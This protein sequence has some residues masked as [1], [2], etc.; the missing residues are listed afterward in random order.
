MKKWQLQQRFLNT[1]SHL[2]RRKRKMWE[3]W[4]APVQSWVH[5]HDHT[6]YHEPNVSTFYT[7]VHSAHIDYPFG[8]WHGR[9]GASSDLVGNLSGEE[10][11]WYI[12]HT[13]FTSNFAQCRVCLN[14]CTS[15]LERLRHQKSMKCCSYL[16]PAYSIIK[17]RGICVVCNI[18]TGREKWGV[19]ICSNLC[20]H[21]WKF[22][23]CQPLTLR[24]ELLLCIQAQ[25]AKNEAHQ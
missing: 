9:L 24:M 25:K 13:V 14:I 7:Y 18:E 1:G 20:D 22:E 19:P 8:K 21:L 3:K 5:Q 17:T 12:G 6:P 11:R 10:Y 23:V 2:E 15:T 4:V 16:A